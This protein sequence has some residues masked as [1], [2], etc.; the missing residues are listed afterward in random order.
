MPGLL[1]SRANWVPPPP[2]LQE[3]VAPPVWIQG[4]RHI[5]FRMRVWGEPIPTMGHTLWYSKY[6]ITIIPR[7]LRLWN[8][9]PLTPAPHI[10]A[11]LIFLA[12]NKMKKTAKNHSM[13]EYPV[14]SITYMSR[15]P[16]EMSQFGKKSAKV[17]H[18]LYSSTEQLQVALWTYMFL[19]FGFNND[20]LFTPS[21]S[22][23]SLY[24]LSLYDP[25]ISKPSVPSPWSVW[26]L[27]HK[28]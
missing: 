6:T 16:R 22:D 27:K 11:S 4:G 9:C 26:I 17:N 24:H 3:S 13:G 20:N 2:Q 1:S 5:H 10:G 28:E 8:L 23:L 21:L 18:C 12:N 7:R 15:K 14:I 25:S 19:K